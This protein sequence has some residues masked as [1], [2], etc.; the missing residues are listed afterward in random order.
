[1]VRA[2]ETW[3][4]SLPRVLPGPSAPRPAPHHG[5][6]IARTRTN[7]E[8]TGVRMAAPVGEVKVYQVNL[9]K[10]QKFQQIQESFRNSRVKKS[11]NMKQFP[12]GFPN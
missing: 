11:I 6:V 8:F 3:E 12:A 5:S 10:K 2:L 4:V 1:M 7:T 9:S